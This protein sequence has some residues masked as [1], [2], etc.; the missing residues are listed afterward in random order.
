[1]ICREDLP[2]M[3]GPELARRAQ[4]SHP[5]LAVR[6]MGRPRGGELSDVDYHHGA[7]SF[8][9]A[10]F[11]TAAGRVL[12]ASGMLLTE[13]CGEKLLSFSSD[14]PEIVGQSGGIREVFDLIDKVRDRDVTV[15][16]RGESGTG[17]ELVARAIHRTGIRAGKPFISVNCAA[18]PESLLES[19]LFGHEK[20]AYTGADSRVVGRF[21]QADGGCLFLDEIGDMSFETQA[22]I[23]RLLEGHEFERL[24]GRTP[25]RVD[26]RVLAATNRDLE[27]AVREHQFREDL[28]YRIGTFPIFIPPLRSRREDIPLLIGAV[29]RNFNRSTEKT[30]SAV[31]E[32]ALARLI[33]YDW[34]GNIRQLENLVRRAAILA[35]GG[36]ITEVGVD[37]GEEVPGG[38]RAGPKPDS[39][40]AA[41]GFAAEEGE[42]P[43][44]R[45]ERIRSLAEAER[46]AV[47]EA[48]RIAD[49]NISRAARGL[50]ISRATL[51]KKIK[52]YGVR[53][54][55]KEGKDGGGDP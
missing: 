6:V 18:L 30:V 4:R 51:Y 55:G 14:Y 52:E 2:I 23:L 12:L 28:Y 45:P 38:S 27:T 11:L 43:A 54:S 50:G 40:P 41:A 33:A 5:R 22:K 8:L 49:N 7:V 48:L 17:K 16:I 25:I 26:V 53:E 36:V 44:P 29:L 34:P 47:I 15:L 13:G 35:G 10:D 32:K 37:T 9:E 20:G 46:E 39:D 19:E 42:P 21:E 1:M 31:S 3:S 24:G